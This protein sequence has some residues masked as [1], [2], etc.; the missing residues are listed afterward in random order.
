MDDVDDVD[1]VEMSDA[2]KVS[3][4]Q[5][6]LSPRQKPILSTF[7]LPRIRQNQQPKPLEHLLDLRSRNGML[8]PCGHGIFA[9]IRYVIRM[10]DLST[11]VNDEMPVPLTCCFLHF[12]VCHLP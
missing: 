2:A 6:L 11:A 10:R 9:Q 8:W 1:D 7:S 3:P 4:L 5:F 12:T